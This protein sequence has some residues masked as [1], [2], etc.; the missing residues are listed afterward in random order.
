MPATVVLGAQWG[1]EGKGKIVDALAK[2]ADIIVRFNGGANAGHTIVIDGIKHPLHLLPSGIL[3]SGKIN[4]VG[5]GVALDLEIAVK[6]VKLAHSFD[7]RVMFD[8]ATPIVLPIHRLIDAAREAAAGSSAL[9]TTRRGIGPLYSDFVLRR[10]LTFVDLDSRKSMTDRLQNAYWKELCAIVESLQRMSYNTTR[11]GF[12]VNNPLSLTETIDYC[13]EHAKHLVVSSGDTR[14]YVHGALTR[15]KNVLFEGAQGV[16]LDVFQGSRPFCTSSMCT[17]A[18]VSATFGV[19]KFERVIGVAKA[20]S[21][22]VGA[23]PFPTELFDEKGE[24]LRRR[25]NEFGTTTGRPRRC[26][27]LD[28]PALRYA[29]RMG[30]ITELVMT[31]LDI[32]SDFSDVQ[33]CSSYGRGFRD[34]DTIT[35][36]TLTRIKTVFEDAP[37][38][39]NDI[40]NLK[41]LHDLP[42]PVLEYLSMIQKVTKTPVSGIGYG[43]ERH[44]IAWID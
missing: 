14:M 13:L 20:Y 40:T 32:L 41:S 43:P 17:L 4:V 26:G 1:D 6:E 29:C 38:W 8:D 30:G 15:K 44:Q 24:E 31:K 21:T 27:W 2:D 35:N 12:G 22:R 39:T 34:H 3:R 19:Y 11:N 9:G 28:L 7:S 5:P 18:G 25:G 36:D 33:L 42:I 10:G 16:M 23:G 37:R